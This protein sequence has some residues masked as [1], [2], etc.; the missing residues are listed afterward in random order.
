M[1]KAECSCGEAGTTTT[2]PPGAST[3]GLP[4]AGCSHREPRSPGAW[5]KTGDYPGNLPKG[6]IA[7]QN[8][9]NIPT[10]TCLAMH[11]KSHLANIWE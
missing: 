9:L 1:K 11:W 10:L 5:P 6:I 2:L 7:D 3:P 8:S 4:S